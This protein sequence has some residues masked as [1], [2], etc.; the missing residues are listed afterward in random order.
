MLY[1]SSD[2]LAGQPRKCRM[3]SSNQLKKMMDENT[4]IESNPRPVL[5][6]EL[7]RKAA[8]AAAERRQRNADAALARLMCLGASQDEAEF[9]L[10]LAAA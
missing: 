2:P 4:M 10:S 1:L 3:Q 5:R 8:V 7:I 6:D 9:A